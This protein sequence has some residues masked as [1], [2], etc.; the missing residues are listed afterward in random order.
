MK[1]SSKDLS[2]YPV[3]AQARCDGENWAFG[4][5]HLQ[6]GEVLQQGLLHGLLSELG[7]ED[8][9]GFQR[10][11]SQVSIGVREASLHL[12]VD[13]PLHGGLRKNQVFAPTPALL[14]E[15]WIKISTAGNQ[16]LNY[17]SF[18]V[19]SWEIVQ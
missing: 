13:L 15:S 4:E 2:S 14:S 8:Q 16:H 3:H 9:H 1:D 19:H 18:L 11:L 12:W 5:A 7:S 10:Q 6:S 17:G